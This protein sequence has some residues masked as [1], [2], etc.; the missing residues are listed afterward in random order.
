[1]GIRGAQSADSVYRRGIQKLLK[2]TG[3]I[4][5]SYDDD[6]LNSHEHTKVTCIL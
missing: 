1:M 3:N 4:L 6:D 2:I 5:G